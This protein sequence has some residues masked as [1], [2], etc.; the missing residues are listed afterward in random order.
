[1]EVLA[2]ETEM[3]TTKQSAGIPGLEGINPSD[4][5]SDTKA[6]GPLCLY[7]KGLLCRETALQL[8]CLLTSLHL[9]FN[10]L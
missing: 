10:S 6:A 7:I 3:A 4:L 2:T 5:L 8:D 1:M 9:F